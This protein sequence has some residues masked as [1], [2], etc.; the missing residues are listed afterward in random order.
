MHRENEA[1]LAEDGAVYLSGV[2]SP[3]A[4]PWEP[5]AEPVLVFLEQ[6]SGAIR[7]KQCR[8]EEMAA[9][10]FWCRRS[11]LEE[12][13]RRYEDGCLRIGRGVI[14]HIPASNVPVL[15]AYSLVMGLLAGNSCSVRIS[16][17]YREQDRE[18]CRIMDELLRRPEHVDM[19]KR[20]SVFSCERDAPAIIRET[21]RCAGCVVWGGDQAIKDIRTLPMRADA[22]QMVFPDR[23]SV[24]ILDA[25]R[26]GDMER[27]ELEALAHRFY[28]DT[29]AMDQNACSSPGFILWNQDGADRDSIRKRWWDA[30]AAQAAGYRMTAHKATVKYEAL[31]RYAMSLDEVQTVERRSNLLYTV[32]L[33]GIPDNPE[34]IRG[35]CR[36]FFE[37]CGDWREALSC[38]AGSRLQTV[39]CFGVEEREIAE[40]AVR[41]HFPG[42][43]RVVPVGRAMEMELVWD[44]QDFISI[45]SRQIGLEVQNASV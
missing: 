4:K 7:R 43:H 10:G 39:T 9:F 31:C 26:I 15:F 27:H 23:Y 22:V 3:D 32:T 14:F 36:L 17:R 38:L 37:Y 34:E 1:V 28:N 41:N 33:S 44:G 8:Y 13:R 24:C 45:L 40:Y 29:Y 30:V 25:G 5:F 18:L 20:I 2:T 42:V 6:L 16:S 21:G 12:F 19:R 11:H 35:I